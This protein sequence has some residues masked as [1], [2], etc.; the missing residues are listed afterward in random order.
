MVNN[1]KNYEKWVSNCGRVTLYRGDCLDVMLS[2]KSALDQNTIDTVITDPPYGLKFMGKKWDHGIP[3]VPF[4]EAVRFVMKPGAMLMAFG[5]TRTF[6]RLAC[7]IEDAGLEIRDC[8]MWLYGS[9]FPKS[10]DISKGIDHVNGESG[11]ALQFT[12]WMRGTGLTAKQINDATKTSMGGHYLTSASQPGIPTRVLFNVLRPILPEV[13]ER[14]ERLIDREEA[15]R[16]IVGVHDC[17]AGNNSTFHGIP[18]EVVLTS[19]ATPAAQ[20]WTGYGTALKPA[21]ELI[22]LAMKPLDGTFA[23]NALAHGVAGL[24]IDG[25]RIGQTVETW[26]SS[27][28]YA[29]GGLA[30]GNY[31]GKTISTGNAPKG[32]WPANVIL[33]ESAA[34]QLDEQS[35]TNPSR[36]FYCPKVSKAERNAGLEGMEKKQSVGGGGTNNTEDDVCGKYGSIKS[37]GENHHPTCKPTKLLRYLARLTKTPSGGIVFD[38]FMG[39]GSM[40]VAAVA[41]GR[42]FIG[43]EKE[44]EYFEIA[45]RRIADAM[46]QPDMFTEGAM[47]DR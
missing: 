45:K 27:R 18:K 28:R 32:R 17:P 20:Q 5:G 6:H 29:P 42:R 4:W 24:N 15:E 7:G 44:P 16:E 8:M 26:P 19:P 34:A 25:G 37:A 30:G 36:Y 1:A 40:G 39:S 9:G 14:I 38:P 47:N 33:D 12:K 21:Y 35:G 13:P 3:G 43:I 23:S 2:P 31:E 22:T 41:E 11:R 10:H 46:I